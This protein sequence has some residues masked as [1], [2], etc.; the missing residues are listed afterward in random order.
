MNPTRRFFTS[1]GGS[2]IAL[3]AAP[4]DRPTAEASELLSFFR[5]RQSVRRYKMDAVPDEHI[6]LIL[7]AAAAAP[8]CM[9]QQPWKFL[10]IRDRDKIGRMRKLTLANLE[11]Q[12]AE[13]ARKNPDM[14][15]ADREAR[16]KEATAMT[17]G[18][19]T[20]PVYIVVLVD[21]ESSCSGYAVKHD[22]PMAAGYLMVAARA[23]GY[24]T[25][26]LTD[27]V[28]D[29]VSREVLQIPARWQRICITPVGIPDG[30]P[31]PKPKKPLDQLIA[32][33]TL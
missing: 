27:G 31:E 2:A 9:N 28:P 3:A 14:P 11:K 4:E 30:W 5:R 25:V 1:F 10:V 8:T 18:Y 26:Y 23:L 33:E 32:Y 22:G 12:F 15:A 19:F 13:F 29:S 6:R 21:T 20:A 7:Q 16:I 24:G 17:E